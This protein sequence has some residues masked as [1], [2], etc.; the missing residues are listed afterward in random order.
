MS[1]NQ[2][3]KYR[4]DIDGLRAVAI[5]LVVIYHAVPTSIPGGFIG[6]DIFFVISGFLISSIIFSG[7]KN[8]SFSFLDFYEK[9]AKRIFPALILVLLTS[10]IVGYYV[11]LPDE[12]SQ[13]GKHITAGA[14]FSQNIILWQEAGYFDVASEVKP[15]MH[16]WSLAIEE[17]YYLVYPL[18]IFFLWQW[19]KNIFFALIVLSLVSFFLCVWF[20][21]DD[22]STA[23]FMPFTRIWELLAGSLLAYGNVF[24]SHQT[25]FWIKKN[26]LLRNIVS[27]IG[28]ILIISSAFIITKTH[29]FPGFLALMPIIGAIFLIHAGND[30]FI[31]KKVLSSRLM[32]FIGLISYPLY[33]W[34]WPILSFLQIVKSGNESIFYR[35]IAITASFLLAWITY[36]FFESP[37]RFK[38]KSNLVT[39][40]L[41]IALV[42]VASIGWFI[43]THNGLQFREIANKNSIIS[44]GQIIGDLG[45]ILTPGCGLNSEEA[46]K[47]GDCTSDKRG[48]AKFVLLG[49]SK[50]AA[51]LP[52][53]FLKSSKDNYWKIIGGN[54]PNGAPLMVITDNPI[55]A[56]YQ[57]VSSIAMN[58]IIN[59]NDI[60]VVVL[61][62][63]T[64]ALFQLKTDYTIEDL[65]DNPNFNVAYEGLEKSVSKFMAAGKKMVIII[66]NPSFKD[67]KQ[68]ITR[69]TAFK[70]LDNALSLDNAPQCFITY[71]NHLKT[72]EKYRELIEKIRQLYPDKIYIFDP[73][74]LLCDIQQN[75]CTPFLKEKLLYGYADHISAVTSTILAEELVPFVEKISNE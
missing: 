50:A 47:F 22:T 28:F 53:I 12:F 66:D 21:Y 71:K 70:W 29:N 13:L 24:H 42:I 8:N 37:V 9:R 10:L 23:F 33:L 46:S 15:L 26:S 14:F 72:S 17:Q 61:A 16:L 40:T 1:E 65:P 35:L 38:M 63:A 6:V 18:L 74:H 49:D 34:H 64:R 11:L 45:S 3:V 27:V 75:K 44:N 48:P 57:S 56:R 55:Y 41:L 19:K 20:T 73:L 25:N 54:G 43:F 62:V 2:A 51:L 60:K 69:K 5:L 36:K 32:I 39:P 58:A 30:A 7:L 4:P 59:D 52:G 68:C 67:P 31:N